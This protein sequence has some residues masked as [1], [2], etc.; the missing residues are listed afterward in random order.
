MIHVVQDRSELP[1]VPLWEV[2]VEKS[3]RLV[4]V[5]YHMRE[6]VLVRMLLPPGR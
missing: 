6:A 4:S 2:R 3:S 5:I 1:G